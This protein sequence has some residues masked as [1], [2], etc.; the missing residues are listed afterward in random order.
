MKGK[1][2][3]VFAVMLLALLVIC[4]ASC[5]GGSNPKSLAKQ[6]A[7]L[8]LEFNQLATD[9]VMSG[10]AKFDAATKKIEAL[11]E[12][13]ENLSEADRAIFDKEIQRL[14]ASMR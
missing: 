11:N 3:A 14:S 1:L 7:D 8:Q 5:G 6:F 9:G 2:K 12:K 13:L 4:M 10:D